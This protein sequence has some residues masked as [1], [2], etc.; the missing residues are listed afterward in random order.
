MISAYEAVYLVIKGLVNVNSRLDIT[1]SS[2]S[3]DH[4]TRVKNLL[5]NDLDV[6]PQYTPGSILFIIIISTKRKPFIESFYELS[7]TIQH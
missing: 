1:N 4:T 6:T 5:V 7:G 2:M 3:K